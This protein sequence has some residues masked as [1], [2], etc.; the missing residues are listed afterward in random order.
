M[1]MTQRRFAANPIATPAGDAVD[2]PA[3]SGGLCV[4]HGHPNIRYIGERVRVPAFSVM[5]YRRI[6]SIHRLKQ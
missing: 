5:V 2:A 6:E 4:T 3:S 1:A